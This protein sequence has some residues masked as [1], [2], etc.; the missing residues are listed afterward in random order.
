MEDPV[1][2]LERNLSGHPLAGLIWERQSEEGLLGLEWDKSAELGMSF[3]SSKTRIVLIGIR[4]QQK[5]TPEQQNMAPMWKKL[6]KNNDLDEPTSIFDHVCLGCTQRY[7][8]LN[9]IILE[10]NTDV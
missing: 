9:E 7:C 4:C 3:C 5:M 2:P 1:V 8:K 6:M 10:E